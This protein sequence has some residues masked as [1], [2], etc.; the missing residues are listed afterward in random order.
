MHHTEKK[1]LNVRL[2]PQVHAAAIILAGGHGMSLQ[3]LIERLILDSAK[4]YEPAAEFLATGK[5]PQ[6]PEGRA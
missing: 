2:E 4:R 5:R 6:L 3:A 1:A